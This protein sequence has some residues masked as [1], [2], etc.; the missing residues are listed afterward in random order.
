VPAASYYINV[1]ALRHVPL[2]MLLTQAEQEHTKWR[3]RKSRDEKNALEPPSATSVASSLCLLYSLHSQLVQLAVGLI[4]KV[5]KAAVIQ[6]ITVEKDE[7]EQV[8]M[9]KKAANEAA[10]EAAKQGWTNVEE[11]KELYSIDASR[12]TFGTL[13]A[14]YCTLAT[15]MLTGQYR[16]PPLRASAFE[17]ANQD[18]SCVSQPCLD[19]LTEQKDHLP[20]VGWKYLSPGDPEQA[21]LSNPLWDSPKVKN[22]ILVYRKNLMDLFNLLHWFTVEY[23]TFVDA[24]PQHAIDKRPVIQSTS[25]TYPMSNAYGPLAKMSVAMLEELVMRQACALFRNNYVFVNTAKLSSIWLS[26][27]IPAAIRDAE[28]N[29]AIT[30][31][32]QSFS[33]LTVSPAVAAQL[34]TGGAALAPFPQRMLRMP[35]PPS[36]S[37]QQQQRRRRS[38]RSPPAPRPQHAARFD[39]D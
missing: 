14:K 37:Q 27:D 24:N 21:K 2:S 11:F 13:E 38:P 18:R 33:L 29:Q 36:H 17:R 1:F 3:D 16:N 26:C 7:P 34:R 5:E 28:R 12:D 39:R 23:T 25:R 30:D 32:L 20:R 31:L 8:Q 4:V 9:A 19:L 22:A 10:S 15:R 6:S 35:P